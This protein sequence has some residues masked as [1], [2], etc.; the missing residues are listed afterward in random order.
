M[1]CV[2]CAAGSQHVINDHLYQA[3]ASFSEVEL[4]ATLVQVTAEEN[5]DSADW[6]NGVIDAGVVWRQ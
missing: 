1:R 2:M 4:D 6:A 5:G 3:Q